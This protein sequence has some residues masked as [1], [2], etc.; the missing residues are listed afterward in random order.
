MYMLIGTK[1]VTK[2]ELEDYYTLDEALKLYSL[3]RM[4]Q[5]IEAV[6]AD[7]LKKK[8]NSRGRR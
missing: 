6:H 7:E 1:V 2:M 4:S 8:A 5:D 3:W